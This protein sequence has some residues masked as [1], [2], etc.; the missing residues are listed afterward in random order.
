MHCQNLKECDS[1]NQIYKKGAYKI[2][3]VD[4]CFILHNAELE[5]FKHT[6]LHS[7]EQA[8]LLIELSVHNRIPHHLS[9]YLLESLRR[10]NEGEYQ[11]KV[12]EL[13]ENKKRKQ[14]Y[15]NRSK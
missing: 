10:I 2:Y 13:I 12:K 3:R 1:L 11:E 9:R 7:F 4:D 6:H 14:V 15:V 5:G 8:K